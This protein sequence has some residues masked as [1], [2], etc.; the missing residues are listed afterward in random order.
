MGGTPDCSV[1]AKERERERKVM[2][3]TW[4]CIV[5]SL[6]LYSPN[7]DVTLKKLQTHRK[8]YVAP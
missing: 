5:L 4:T 1:S 7:L 2:P 6:Y 3:T 8:I